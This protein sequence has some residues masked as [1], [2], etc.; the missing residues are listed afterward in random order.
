MCTLGLVK[1]RACSAYGNHITVS[2]KPVDACLHLIRSMREGG[3]QGCRGDHGRL[4][5][6]IHLGCAGV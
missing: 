4:V 6:E 2:K 3:E 5:L 1:K